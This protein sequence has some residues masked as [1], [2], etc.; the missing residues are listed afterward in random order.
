MGEPL[1]ITATSSVGGEIE[2]RQNSRVIGKVKGDEKLE[3]DSSVLG[4]GKSKLQGFVVA[5]KKTIASVKVEV[6]IL[7]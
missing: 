3:I 1:I 5:G 2:I 7:P 4:Q 6:E